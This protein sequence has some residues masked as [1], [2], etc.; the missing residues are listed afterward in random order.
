MSFSLLFALTACFQPRLSA[1]EDTEDSDSDEL[2]PVLHSVDPLMGSAAGGQ[3][4]TLMGTRLDGVNEVLIGGNPA[5]IESV[6]G[7]EV[8]VW[9]PSFHVA[10]GFVDIEVQTEKGREAFLEDGFY[11]VMDRKDEQGIVGL[12]FWTD[13]QGPIAETYDDQ[14]FS[15][16]AFN[17]EPEAFDLLDLLG[18]PGSCSKSSAQLGLPGHVNARGLP[19]AEL[20]T[21]Q[22]WTELVRVEEGSASYLYQRFA[23]EEMFGSGLV[24][25][26]QADH[27]DW[28]PFHVTGAFVAAQPSV[29]RSPD[30]EGHS[31]VT[32]QHTFEWEPQEADYVWIQQDRY[33]YVWGGMNLGYELAESLTCLVEDTGTFTV[34]SGVWGGW[35]PSLDDLVLLTFGGLWIS[36]SALL[37]DGSHFSGLSASVVV[38]YAAASN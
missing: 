9:T 27:G 8:E 20:L 35:N 32:R 6:S 29:L 12:H 24:H 34:P 5:H 16:V 25:T 10:D 22:S 3:L 33:A 31:A 4:I 18:T 1:V 15:L 2:A 13:Y 36:E 37:P 26:F 14:G 21:S 7:T 19:K 17:D 23:Q 30:L 38:G 11:L 28:L